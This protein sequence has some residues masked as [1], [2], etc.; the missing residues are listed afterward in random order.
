[1][2]LQSFSGSGCSPSCHR[3][4]R[5]KKTCYGYSPSFWLFLYVLC[6]VLAPA[7]AAQGN[8]RYCASSAFTGGG[9]AAD[10]E[11]GAPGSGDPAILDTP[12]A[13]EELNPPP[14]PPPVP[15]SSSE[16]D[17][18]SESSSDESIGNDEPLPQPILFRVFAFGYPPEH[19]ALGFRKGPEL[20][21]ARRQLFADSVL[22]ANSSPGR[23]IEVKDEPVSEASHAIWIPHW[24]V[25]SA[26]AFVLFD[27]EQVGRSTC[28]VFLPSRPATL[29]H[30]RAAISYIWR[31]D[32]TVFVP[33]YSEYPLDAVDV[34]PVVHG[35]TIFVQ[36][37]WLFPLF[38]RD[39]AEAFR[40]IDFWGADIAGD[41]V[42]PDL[43]WGPEA[44]QM[45]C[46]GDTCLFESISDESDSGLL[47][48]IASVFSGTL[49]NPILVRPS[50]RPLL[51]VCKGTSLSDIIC[52]LPHGADATD[53][54]VFLDKRKAGQ[55]W[56]A[57]HLRCGD[58]PKDDLIEVLRLEVPRVFGYKLHIEG[59]QAFPDFL[60]TEHGQ[61]LIVE[62]VPETDAFD[63]IGAD[64]DDPD[65]GHSGTDSHDPSRSDSEGAADRSRSPRGRSSEPN[66][67][68][69]ELPVEVERRSQRQPCDQEPEQVEVK[70]NCAFFDHHAIPAGQRGDTPD[71]TAPFRHGSRRLCSNPTPTAVKSGSLTLSSRF[72]AFGIT[73]VSCFVNLEAVILPCF[74]QPIGPTDRVFFQEGQQDCYVP[75]VDGSCPV[76]PQH[77]FA[78]TSACCDA[79]LV[80]PA[81]GKHSCQ[82]VWSGYW[83]IHEVI[84]GL[85]LVTLLEQAKGAEF[86]ATC[87]ELALFCAAQSGRE[88]LR[89]SDPV[90]VSLVDCV[91]C[92]S[93]QVAVQELQALLPS[94]VPVELTEWQDWLDCDLSAVLTECQA[95]KAV[96]D[97][98]SAYESWYD[99]P[100]APE[101]VHIYTDGSAGQIVGRVLSPASWAF[102]V[103]AISSTRQAYLG[104]AFGVTTR[105]GS[106][107]FLGENDDEALTGEQLALARAFS[108]VVEAS[109][110]FRAATFILH[111]DCLAAGNGGFGVFKLP[112]DAK[113]MQPS[114]LSRSLLFSGNVPKQLP[115]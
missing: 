67:L 105:F 71:S 33:S 62:I 78:D 34:F 30:V 114:C 110:A 32:W 74:D 113:T 88:P 100:F 3:G 90:H 47:S 29:E 8:A 50:V 99:F 51:P 58:I 84:E 80:R 56:D 66:R 35:S 109:C 23:F 5:R 41:G 42:P 91:P 20:D 102:N 6:W 87:L 83:R 94:T 70:W 107:F 19:I 14:P 61:T 31:E 44:I 37:D 54:V 11:T 60:R 108:W 69:S 81:L 13:A 52:L 101:A 28:V 39:S 53:I 86:R 65:H 24:S 43:P 36:T 22:A 112:S 64:E 98:L 63:Y 106:P 82:S 2:V 49:R 73:F 111:F 15:S 27:L 10:R 18:S 17:S 96:W 104:H 46:E 38:H 12:D 21:Y 40:S 4:G 68:L 76:A 7:Y 1:M 77:P 55:D 97:W 85:E 57:I 115:M 9:R 26:G 103:W 95:C 79:Q 89:P 92:S 72:K 45:V 93:F 75:A 25:H 48:R 59:G 16:D